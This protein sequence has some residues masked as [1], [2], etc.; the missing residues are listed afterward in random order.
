MSKGGRFG[1]YGEKKRKQKLKK[2]KG[3]PL[4]GRD[5]IKFDEHRKISPKH[6]NMGKR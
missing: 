6:P 3:K 1:K 2:I 4:A 5:I